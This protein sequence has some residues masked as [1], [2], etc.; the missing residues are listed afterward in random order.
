MV[1]LVAAL[2]ILEGIGRHLQRPN[3]V[4]PPGNP[5]FLLTTT[6]HQI[7]EYAASAP[8][9]EIVGCWATAIAQIAHH[10]RLSPKGRMEYTTTSGIQISEDLGSDPFR[11]D[12]ILPQI[13]SGSPPESA[14]ETARYI[15]EV[16]VAIQK[17]FG[18]DGIMA[19]D[20]FIGRLRDHLGATAVLHEFTKTEY[21]ESKE[22]VSDILKSELDEGRP[23][24]LYFDNGKDWGHAAVVDGYVQDGDRLLVHLNM[25]WEGRDNGWYD[26]YEKVMGVRDDL[27]N[28][29]VL[30]IRPA[31]GEVGPQT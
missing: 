16:A 18:G 14:Q 20:G 27:E 23:L 21:L 29:F 3:R 26:P 28:R 30:T 9:G 24:M 25:G 12:R 17:D 5:S 8:A 11:F 1:V 6:W 19:H 22:E 31:G 10:H 4:T 15:Y 13:D 2:V 7:D